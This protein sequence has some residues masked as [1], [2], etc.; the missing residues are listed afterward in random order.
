M[1]LSPRT[2]ENKHVHGR[3]QTCIHIELV[4]VVV[5]VNIALVLILFLDSYSFFSVFHSTASKQ[6]NSQLISL[7]ETEKGSRRSA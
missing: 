4:A 3:T 5:V 6:K 7:E 2:D 1:N